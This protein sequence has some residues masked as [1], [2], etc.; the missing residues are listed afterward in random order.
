M[1]NI[2]NIVICA[3]V[4]HGKTV[5]SD[6]L[7]Q[8]AGLISEDNAGTQRYTDNREDEKARGITIKSTGVSMEYEFENN[9]Y[10]INLV[11]TP[12]HVDFS[13]EVSAG[14]RITDGAIVVV[15]AIEGVSVQ[16][17]TVLRQA[18]AEQVKPILLIN[19]LDRYIFELKLE[20]EEIYQRLT[21]IIESVNVIISTFKTDNSTLKLD[22]S[23]ELGNVFF[24][25]GLH[26]WGFGLHNFAKMYTKKFG[27]DENKLMKLF[28]GDNYFDTESKKITKDTQRNN[29]T[30]ERTFCKFVIGP[31]LKL[32][33]HIMNKEQEEYKK[34]LNVLDIKLNLQDLAKPEKDI[35]KLVM[36]RF[37]PLSETLLYGIVNHLPSPSQAQQYRY[38]TLYDGLLEDDTALAIKNCDPNGHLMIYISKMIPMNDGGRFYAFGRVFSG[39]VR[40]GQKVRI[41]GANYQY[42]KQ[43]DHFENKS[44]QRVCRM[45][46][47]KVEACNEISC[48][49]TVALVGID[50][51]LLKSG[52][53]T[54]SPT[55]Y[56]IK[57][58]KFSVSPVVRVSV[59]PKNPSELP[60]SDLI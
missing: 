39:T 54:T 27:I 50:Q 14:L 53:I 5:L 40:S 52:T 26:S 1:E 29:T 32:V 31:I 17:E 20:P 10:Q 6:A 4:D 24:G 16:T 7:I 48:G 43:D 25:S 2:R 23:P 21:R 8:H 41:M 47:G 59:S 38:V 42:G 58:M 22:L 15:D 13:S 35:Y 19:K 49:N 36:R 9:K 60:K 37:L 34:M 46:G 44:I 3:H 30:L 33:G 12:G 11:D 28:W 45:V 57:T 56:P 18:L 55:A 51:Y